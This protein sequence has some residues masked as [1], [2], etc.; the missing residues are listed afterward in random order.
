MH[1]AAFLE[2][3]DRIGARLCRDA[4]WSGTRANWLGWSLDPVGVSWT[5]V[6][7]AQSPA[8]YGGT[9]GIALF[10]A[11]L[12]GFTRDRL[13]KT[14]ALGAI[15]QAI[16]RLTEIPEAGRPA[17]YSG[18]AGIAW[19]TI[20]VGMAFDDDRIVRRGLRDLEAA[21][22]TKPNPAWV[23][24]IGGSA[25]TVQALL[26][27]A[28]RFDCPHAVDLALEHGRMLLD[29][30]VK[31]DSGWSWDTL[32]G[33]TKK[34]LCGYGHGAA[35]IG[36]AMAELWAEAGE[37]HFRYGCLEAFRY[38]R[39][40]FSDEHHNWPDLRD[41]TGFA[42]PGQQA[43]AAAWCHGGPGIGLARL[44]ALDLIEDEEGA[45]LKDLNEAIFTTMNIC[46]NVV[47]PTSGSLCLCH[48]LGGNADLLLETGARHGRGDLQQAA[49][50]VG[51]QAIA[52]IRMPDLPW[53][54]GITSGGETPNLM[55][56]LSG[57]GHFFLRLY[58]S[59]KTS[60]VLLLGPVA[61]AER[62]V[63][64]AV[65]SAHGAR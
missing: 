21:A 29:S 18:A 46:S 24:V 50:N 25:G 36:A 65:A 19:A 39:S 37:E 13:Q 62:F 3:A 43:Y 1:E 17:V 34:N 31:S 32:Q 53:P 10:L 28:R 15:N 23:D 40:H 27:V 59:V 20:E 35:G 22:R 9:A 11:R 63:R 60:S 6:H 42:P 49:E 52:Q 56:G 54:C 30:A 55:L 64:A 41:M 61:S 47:F 2:A 26:S 57:I 5:P 33:T 16:D 8:L 58:D 4:L 38:E 7:K 51:R 48:G 45:V 12:Y 14:A 44:R